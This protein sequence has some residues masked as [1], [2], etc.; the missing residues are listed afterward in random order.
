VRLYDD[1]RRDLLPAV[2]LSLALNGV[3]PPG[4]PGR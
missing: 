2:A 3:P 4:T 1:M